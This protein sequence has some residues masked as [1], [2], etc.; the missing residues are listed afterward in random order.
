MSAA[1]QSVFAK[2]VRGELPCYKVFEND[3]VL[4]FLDINPLADG[5]TLIIPKRAAATIDQLPDEVNAELGRCVGVVARRILR[6]TGA[7]AYNVLQNN[8][9]SAGQEV[10]YVHYHVIPRKPGDGLGFRWHPGKRTAAEFEALQ[11]A[12]ASAE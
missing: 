1:E 7:A 3:S 5:H 10:P 6:V 8:G 2:I 11:A 12:I 4:A 9:A